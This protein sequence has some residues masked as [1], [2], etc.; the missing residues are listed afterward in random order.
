MTII[1]QLFKISVDLHPAPMQGF[2][3]KEQ[4]SRS[5]PNLPRQQAGHLLHA[6]AQG[7]QITPLETIKDIHPCAWKQLLQISKQ[8]TV[9]PGQ[10]A[11]FLRQ[12]WINQQNPPE[13]ASLKSW[14]LNPLATRTMLVTFAQEAATQAD[15]RSAAEESKKRR[16]Q[17]Q[18]DDQRLAD[19]FQNAV[20]L[21]QAL[22]HYVEPFC[23]A[24][25]L[26]IPE[27][28]TPERMV[29]LMGLSAEMIALH[30][31][32]QEFS[33]GKESLVRFRAKLKAKTEHNQ[34]LAATLPE[35]VKAAEQANLA[36]EISI[37]EKSRHL[38]ASVAALF[39]GAS[40]EAIVGLYSG[41]EK[42]TRVIV[43]KHPQAGIAL[44]VGLISFTA[45]L[46]AYQ[47]VGF[48]P[49]EV[50]KLFAVN[51]AMVTGLAAF[52]SAIVSAVIASRRLPRP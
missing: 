30:S 6:L 33:R 35:H 12:V 29:L 1:L 11:D 31:K 46:A 21:E 8:E 42:A 52:V 2:L 16:V 15:E 38:F 20:R 45:Q 48:V 50:L 28:N 14:L 13:R 43:E 22:G 17:V 4:E 37:R 19:L 27:K 18:A 10:L 24:R 34:M 7:G 23:R 44:A 26:A 39:S 5:T 51:S 36:K 9:D 32:G 40:V 41:L 47:G 3:M 25:N 49:G